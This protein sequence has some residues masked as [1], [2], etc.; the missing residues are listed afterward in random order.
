MIRDLGGLFL[1]MVLV[2]ILKCLWDLRACKHQQLGFPISGR[3]L[4]LQ[5]GKYRFYTIGERPSSK[6]YFDRGRL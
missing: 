1:V 4:C 6:W 3:Q 5:C 2:I